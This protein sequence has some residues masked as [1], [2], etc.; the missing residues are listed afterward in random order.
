MTQLP[1]KRE[2]R[3][4]WRNLKHL[5][6]VL[7]AL[8]RDE[9][10]IEKAIKATQHRLDV[11]QAALERVRVQHGHVLA[12]ISEIENAPDPHQPDTAKEPLP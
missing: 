2:G 4:T 7:S 6:G 12:R 5:R 11:Q 1:E 8:R 10:K 3:S 9:S